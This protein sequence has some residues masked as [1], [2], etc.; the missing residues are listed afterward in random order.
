VIAICIYT[1][2]RHPAFWD[3]PDEFEPDRFTAGNSAGRHKFAYIPFGAGPR[4][5]IGNSLGLME[6]SL[7]I[8]N[9]AQHFELHLVPDSNVSPQAIF[10]LRPARDLMMSLQ[11]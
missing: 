3:R 11:A 2:H 10:V 1:L 7:I 6:G 5:C 4:Q 8:A 9:V